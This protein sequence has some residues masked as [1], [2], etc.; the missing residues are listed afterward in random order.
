VTGVGVI[1]VD[2]YE[3]HGVFRSIVS[4]DEVI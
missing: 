3:G 1:G 4:D 2:N